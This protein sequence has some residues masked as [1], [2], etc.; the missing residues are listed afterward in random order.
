MLIYKSNLRVWSNFGWD[1]LAG[2]TKAKQTGSPNMKR[3]VKINFRASRRSGF[4]RFSFRQDYLHLFHL[5]INIDS[6]RIAELDFRP[7]WMLTS[8]L[9]N[10][11]RPIDL[12]SSVPIGNPHGIYSR[13][14]AVLS[15]IVIVSQPGDCYVPS[16]IELRNTV[17][18]A[19]RIISMSHIRCP[20]TN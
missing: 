20:V 12:C 16:Y 14:C 13:R 17:T 15:C 6:K 10:P 8:T 2:F 19:F 7:A 11:Y 3:V 4:C 18:L 9:T 1:F 5:L